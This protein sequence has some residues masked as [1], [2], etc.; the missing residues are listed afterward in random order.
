[1]R[2]GCDHRSA[3]ISELGKKISSVIERSKQAWKELGSGK[4]D[5]RVSR[6]DGRSENV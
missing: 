4:W 1:M 2:E 5:E 3:N 6:A